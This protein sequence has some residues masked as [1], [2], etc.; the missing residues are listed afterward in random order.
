LPE[1]ENTLAWLNK[2]E[3]GIISQNYKNKINQI[4]PLS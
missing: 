4:K 3:I 2:S 1:K